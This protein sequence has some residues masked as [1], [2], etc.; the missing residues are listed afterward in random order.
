[1]PDPSADTAENISSTPEIRENTLLENRVVKLFKD[2]PKTPLELLLPKI[3]LV[4]H[5]LIQLNVIEEDRLSRLTSLTEGIIAYKSGTER[6]IGEKE[7]RW[8]MSQEAHFRQLLHTNNLIEPEFAKKP[9]LDDINRTILDVVKIPV[10]KPRISLQ[11][12]ETETS[13]WKQ[14]LGDIND[15]ANSQSRERAAD[16]QGDT[17]DPASKHK[18]S[19]ENGNE[20]ERTNSIID[21]TQTQKKPPITMKNMDARKA[22]ERIETGQPVSPT[23][24]SEQDSPSNI[25]RNPNKDVVGRQLRETPIPTPMPGTLSSLTGAAA[26]PPRPRSDLRAVPEETNTK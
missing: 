7:P 4:E 14:I 1:M 6:V 2:L 19:S 8:T 24:K 20:P 26:I 22:Q 18:G 3:K 21:T 13:K 16:E 10:A 25:S 17:K 23:A 5:S 9:V 15:N 12:W 11:L